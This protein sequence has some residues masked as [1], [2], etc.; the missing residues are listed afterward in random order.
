MLIRGRYGGQAWEPGGDGSPEH[1]VTVSVPT[2]G[3]AGAY[4]SS[5]EPIWP[6]I[7]QVFAWGV[8]GNVLLAGAP[9]G[10]KGDP[11]GFSL[12]AGRFGPLRGCRRAR[13]SR[14]CGSG[15]RAMSALP[16]LERLAGVHR[17]GAFLALLRVQREGEPGP[18]L[19]GPF[20]GDG[21]R[22]YPGD[23]WSPRVGSRG[24]NIVRCRAGSREDGH[25]EGRPSKTHRPGAMAGG[26]CP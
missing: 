4:S 12:R 14:A 2:A 1:T 23:C 8:G 9:R 20:R 18:T 26:F 5:R 10:G 15:S 25:D 3:R 17:A 6:E 22:G 13:G 11:D 19:R 16:H 24:R 21:W 7:S